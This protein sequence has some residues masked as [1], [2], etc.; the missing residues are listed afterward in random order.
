MIGIL[1][2][3][4]LTGL[5][6]YASPSMPLYSAKDIQLINFRFS[7]TRLEFSA[8]ILA[9]VEIDNDNVVGG[10][11]YSAHV[12]IYYPDWN[13][14]LQNIGY[15]Q[16]TKIDGQDCQAQHDGEKGPVTFMPASRSTEEK[17]QEDRGVCISEE[18]NKPSPFF[19]V[20]SRGVSQSKSG[21]MTIYLQDV[22]P[23]VYLNI[24]WHL[25]NQWGSIDLLV[26]GVAHVKS[27]LGVPLSLGV[28]CDNFLDLTKRPTQIVGRD[29]IV[30]RIST[31]WSGLEDL[32]P[33]VKERVLG[34]YFKYDGDIF[35]KRVNDRKGSSE[36]PDAIAAK[37]L[38][39][40]FSSSEVVMDW[41]DF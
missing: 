6:Y 36:G 28:I 39:D 22:S 29:C 38:A 3:A 1:T 34:Y 27:P 41:H 40:F 35:Q 23:K 33:E 26:S 16:E 17:N 18:K 20:Q 25:L 21:A 13:G 5:A 8:K 31:G 15:L 11:L 24:I 4:F 14:E 10:D 7:M 30:E 37:S 9:G 2:F 32:A 12:D 19:S